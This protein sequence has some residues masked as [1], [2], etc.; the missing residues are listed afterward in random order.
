MINDDYDDAI[1]ESFSAQIRSEKSTTSPAK[2]SSEAITATAV[3]EATVEAAEVESS[4]V[5]PKA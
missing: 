3:V 5:V 2:E 1:D 4:A